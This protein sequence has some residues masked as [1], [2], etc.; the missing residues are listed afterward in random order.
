MVAYKSAKRTFSNNIKRIAKQYENDEICRA[1]RLAEV[2]RNSFWRL[3]KQC[4]NSCGS[5]N[6]SIKRLDGVVVNNLP[7]V[8][9]VWRRH[10]ANLGTPKNKDNFDD[11]HFR[12]VTNFVRLYNDG[13]VMDDDF[14]SDPFTVEE[15]RSAVKSLNKGKAAGFDQITAEHIAFANDSIEIILQF[16]YNAIRAHE[17]IPKCFRTGIQIPL[18]KGKD[19]DILDPNNYRGITLLYTFNKVFEILV[20][21][22][23]KGWWNDEHVISELQGACK[24]GLSCLH[25]ALLL[26]ET[27][28]TSME[29]NEHCF[30]AFFDVAKAFDTVWTD[31]LFKQIYDLGI[32]GKTWRLLYRCYI[33]FSCRV[34]VGTNLSD[35]YGLH[36]GIHR[37]GYLSLLKYTVFINSLSVSL[38]NPDLCAKMYTTPSTPVGY[39][40]DLAAC[41]LSKRKTDAAMLAVYNYGC[42]WRYDFNARK[43][44]VLVYGENRR[45]HQ[46]NRENRLFMLGPARVKET[47]KYDHVG[48]KASIYSDSTSGIEE[49]IGKARRALNAISGL[50]IRKNGI[51]IATCNIIFW[52]IIIPIAIFGCEL[53]L[54]DS[55]SIMMLETFQIYAGNVYNVFLVNLL[56][57]VVSLVWGGCAFCV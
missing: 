7:D 47:A 44:G 16:L 45:T 41:C 56:I 35:S 55:N 27:V 10:F 4:R 19:L 21:H 23:L 6:I 24:S 14:L 30:V 39:A 38:R 15:I 37:G 32:T 3:V 13:N 22:R 2:D 52:T 8:L 40:D 42:K 11:V 53:W 12:E 31:G 20:W 26:R 49:R 33:D 57:Y 34:R 48:V 46:I 43:S 50:G 9:E 36:C 54:L 5:T 1:V 28:A 17:V 29:E 18:F 25:T 51:T